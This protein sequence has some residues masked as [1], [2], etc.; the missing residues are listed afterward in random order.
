MSHTIIII[1]AL[2]F[3]IFCQK[4]DFSTMSILILDNK[5]SGVLSN[6]CGEFWDNWSFNSVHETQFHQ[7]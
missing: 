4:S 5:I 2:I 7:K 6:T 3:R 1:L